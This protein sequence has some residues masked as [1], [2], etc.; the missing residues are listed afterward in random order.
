MQTNN[1]NAL[2]ENLRRLMNE[3]GISAQKLSYEA[4]IPASRIS[5]LLRGSTRNP[6]LD[7]MLG[8]ARALDVTIDDLVTRHGSDNSQLA[9]H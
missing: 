8:L 5:Q 4:R 2:I 7:T 1:E 6:T 9:G 3:K